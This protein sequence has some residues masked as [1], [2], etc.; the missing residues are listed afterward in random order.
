MPQF[1]QIAAGRPLKT[2]N[3]ELPFPFP[4]NEIIE[5]WTKNGVL[6]GEE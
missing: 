3:L 5:V 6:G 1:W 2:Y 4:D